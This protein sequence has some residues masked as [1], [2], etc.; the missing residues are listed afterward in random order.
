V[1][2]D[3]TACGACCV[4]SAENRAEGFT[5]YVEVDP[6]APL[7]GKPELRKRYVVYDTAGVPHL[8]LDPAGRCA[9]LRGKLG[10]RVSCAIYH[11]RQRG[12]RLVMPEDR[13]CLRAREEQG[14]ARR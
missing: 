7:L 11:Y 8:R 14:L 2:L 4:N 13:N 6:D 3:C 12:C 1:E 10:V 9:A 5:G